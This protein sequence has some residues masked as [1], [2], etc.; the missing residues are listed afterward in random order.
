MQT[1]R[2]LDAIIRRVPARP[3]AVSAFEKFV[4]IDC[5]TK[6]AT[7]ARPWFREVKNFVVV[8]R[9]ADGQVVEYDLPTIEVRDL[10]HDRGIGLNFKC[11]VSCPAGNEERAV[12]ALFDAEQNASDVFERKI[13]QWVDEFIGGRRGDFI[14]RYF[15]LKSDLLSKL[16]AR[17]RDEMGLDLQMRVSLD[18]ETRSFSV[19]EFT[20]DPLLVRVKDYHEPQHLKI[21]CQLEIDPDTKIYA[22]V[23]RRRAGELKDAIGPQARSFFE[24]NVT[25]E[26]F[27]DDLNHPDV[28]EPFKKVLNERLRLEGRRVGFFHLSSTSSDSAL[29]QFE[30]EL[31]V[32]V[33][34]QEFPEQ[35]TI[36]NH[37][38]MKRRNIAVY[39]AKGSRKLNEWLTEQLSQIIPDVLFYEKYIDLLIDFH[40]EDT[41]EG[42][43]STLKRTIRNRLSN[44]AQKIGY[45]LKYLT[46]IPNV[47]PLTWLDF[48]TITVEGKFETN[49]SNFFVKLS[50]PITVRLQTLEDEK[51]RSRLNRLEDIPELMRKKAHTVVSQFLHTVD[52]ER[53]YTTFLFPNPEKYPNKQA[54]EQEIID[55][56]TEVLE[57][58][59]AAEIASIVPKIVDTE[60]I[61]RWREL[62]EKVC[63]FDFEVTPLRGGE[64]IKFKGKFQVE[65]IAENGW[66]KFE[67][68]KA[69]I[70]DIRK[71]LEADLC[72]KLK[73]ASK[74]E[75]LFKGNR[76]LQALHDEI[77]KFAVK[78][79]EEVYGIVIKLTMIDR[80]L[81]LVEAAINEEI[82]GRNHSAILGAQYR[83]EAAVAADRH[84]AEKKEEEVKMLIDERLRLGV[85]GPE[86]QIEEFENRLKEE[87]A[88]LNPDRVPSIES[89]EEILNPSLAGEK[90]LIDVTSF[91]LLKA[92]E[93]E[94]NNGNGQDHGDE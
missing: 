58:S 13:R 20:V 8:N 70:D 88:K 79:I 59:F 1:V 55:R 14:H 57:Q 3:R 45:E 80:D 85:D 41:E 61:I 48:F 39:K 87:R 91:R 24:H 28:I 66:Y 22:N 23:Y 84:F 94:A 93:P 30:F 92:Q 33:K 27:Y 38:R 5:K 86:D 76:H 56:I 18:G 75:L 32:K 51:V 63:D 31:D 83:R 19:L 69:T 54:I 82:I 49:I 43:G 11:W 21:N 52:P 42:N 65:H 67:S 47:K 74:E 78:A 73:T 50:I 71:Y 12:E 2:P 29:K 4:M 10:E 17:A 44:E 34:L 6:K 77:D 9:N 68:R 16:I 60:P 40:R 90:T 89:V 7:T 46:T 72:A 35:I 26:Q 25:L 64:P 53:F 15:E 62:Q 36:S 37:A 81:T